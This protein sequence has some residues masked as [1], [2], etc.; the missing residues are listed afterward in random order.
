MKWYEEWFNSPLYEKMYAERDDEE[1]SR[2]ADFL[3]TLVPNEHYPNVLDLGCG[4]GRHSLNFARRGYN[5][6]GIDLSPKAIE[7]A[8]NKAKKEELDIEFLVRDMR[9]PL[10]RNFDVIINLFTSFGY[11]SSDERNEMVLDSIRAMMHEQSVV[12][13]DYMN[14]SYTLENYIRCEE[15]ELDG[16]SYEINRFVSDDTIN[17]EMV[18][19]MKDGTERGYRERVKLYDLSWFKRMMNRRGAAIKDVFGDYSGNTFDSKKSPRMI[20]LFERAKSITKGT[21]VDILK[22]G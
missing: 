20:M 2:L 21:G 7:K 16:I 15:G 12:I 19:H 3:V 17:K 11:F 18:F 6:T 10:D 9:E 13:I 8:A 14:V 5:V 4:R 1:A 22:T